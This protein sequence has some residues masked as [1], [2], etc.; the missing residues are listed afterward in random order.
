MKLLT[1][2]AGSLFV[3]GSPSAR[4]EEATASSG[5]GGHPAELTQGSQTMII[6]R[7]GSQPSSQGPAEYFTG[8]GRGDPL[9]QAKHPSRRAGA[10]PTIQ[11]RAQTPWHA[12]PLCHNPI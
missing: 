10:P 5:A 7:S 12:L 3:L 4:P 11:P 2:A 1:A 9:F 6:T 8:S